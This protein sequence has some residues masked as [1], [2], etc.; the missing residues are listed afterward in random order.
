MQVLRY[1]SL[2]WIL[3]LISFATKAQLQEPDEVWVRKQMEA[4]SL[5]EKI[6][7]LFT[8]RAYGKND[9][10]HIQS[11][12]NQI[13][14]FHVGGICFFQ[15]T[16][17]TQ[18]K[19]TNLYQ[20][21]S[22]LPLLISMDAEWGLGMRLKQDGF[23]FPKQITLGALEDN[24]LI[25]QVGR[26]QALQLKKLGVHLNFAPVLDINNNP[27]NPVINERSFGDDKLKVCAKSYAFMKGLQDGGVLACAKHF[28]GHGDTDVD[29]HYDLPVLKHS[30]ARLDS[31]ELFPF[32]VMTSTDLASVMIAHLSIPSLEEDAGKP[33]SLSK[34]IIRQILRK[35]MKFDGLVITDALEMKAVSKNFQ[36]GELE[37]DA[38]RAGNDILLLSE[39]LEAAVNA[40]HAA[41]NDNKLKLEDIESSVRRILIAK[42][43]AGLHRTAPAIDSTV[44]P[45]LLNPPSARALRDKIYRQAITLVR[46]SLQRIPIRDINQ[47][48]VVISFG[49]RTEPVFA[50]R[51]AQYLPLKTFSLTREDSLSPDILSQVQQSDLVVVS[52]H[53]LNYKE[54]DRYGLTEKTLA[55][56][57]QLAELKPLTGVVF[58]A[59]Y[60]MKYLESLSSVMLAYEDNIHVHD[61]AA[62][63]LV[64]TDAMKGVLPVT[65]DSS[66]SS[67]NSIRRPSLMR[68][69]F[70]V[71]E[72]V[73]LDSRSL[74]GI[75]SVAESVIRERA[76]P[77]MQVLISRNG[78]IV[79][80]KSYGTLDYV[81]THTTGTEHLYDL[82]SITKI[83]ASAP[84][85]MMLHDQ[86]MLD[87]SDRLGAHLPFLKNSNKDSI[88]FRDLMLHQAG[89]VSW[90]PFY[91]S[92]LIA[93]DTLNLQDP[94]FYKTKSSDSFQIQLG[95]SLYARSSIIN[96]VL[97]SLRNSKL[98]PPGKYV[99]SDLGFY[100][101]PSLV[102]QHYKKSF[103][104][105]LQDELYQPLGMRRTF[106]NPLDRGIS[107]NQ[108]APS[109]DDHFFRQ[110]IVCGRVHDMGAALMNGI[111][112][113]AGLFA[114][115]RDV[116]VYMQ[117]LL[118]LGQYGGREYFSSSTVRM[119]TRRDP[120]LG[121][122]ALCFDLND[123]STND[124]SY[125]SALASQKTFGHQGFTGTCVWADP[126]HDIVYV[127]LSNRTYPNGSV[128]LL[129]KQKFRKRIQDIVYKSLQDL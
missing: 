41:L 127:F 40:I 23:H 95:Q 122:R 2:V 75:D 16:A 57:K 51:L 84:A 34:N 26:E 121:R 129:H 68:M 61:I 89:L 38:L 92:T 112:G 100:L 106:F 74:A 116:A 7:Q 59:P 36:A 60:A 93:P 88:R 102:F 47:N 44:V 71:P 49:A 98:N 80:E 73:G 3:V 126:E 76:A 124:P 70:S 125:V 4:M 21:R 24:S 25:Y 10:A 119:F 87:T 53:G 86:N 5:D 109:E 13:E 31:F 35:Q 107:V 64:G 82:A 42:S 1:S 79:F 97:D 118:N 37:V 114:N 22:K 58:G 78:K 110:Q 33:A 103:D 90:I 128:N 120:A 108:I 91:K 30:R 9:S 104:H 48:T 65:V 111:S 39:N 62:Q 50:N 117:C 63:L 99:Y 69:G 96:F 67:G 101:M 27:R 32:R 11:V 14:K 17:E 15:G 18:A 72:E 85:L 77:G 8:I 123:S 43:K 28:P 20:S 105:F 81:F 29:S 46:D 19:L 45:T 115:A 54:R 113:H 12:L 52:L 55:N 66:L 83:M 6:G 56:L 94:F